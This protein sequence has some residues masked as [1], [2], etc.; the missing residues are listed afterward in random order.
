M[1]VAVVEPRKSIL[2]AMASRYDMEPEA[3]E[4]TLRN[5]VAKPARD[6][7][8]ITREEM[9]AC[10][11]VA[12]QYGLNPL[13]RELYFFPDAKRGG[14]VPVVGVDGWCRIIN[15]HPA[16][17][18]VEFDT[19]WHPSG[20]PEAVTCT[21]HRKDRSR[22]VRVTEYFSECARDT[23]PWKKSPARMLRHK[24]LIQCARVAFGFAGLVDEDDAGMIDVT[25]APRPPRPPAGPA[26]VTRLPAGVVAKPASTVRKPTEG[27]SAEA[28]APAPAREDAA[29]EPVE[30]VDEETGEVTEAAQVADAGGETL[31]DEARAATMEGTRKF[32]FWLAKRDISEVATLQPHIAELTAAAKQ[33][34]GA[35]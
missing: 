17:D 23:D 12:N 33:A 28:Y 11:V 35:A 30:V 14:V 31:L 6:G 24:A 16:F 8:E 10:L 19:E 25:P 32:R 22:P 2:A 13:L 15:E 21:I 27:R 34:D 29:P 3:F 1:S 20:K 18:G 9:A 5:T 26:P 4:R 7:R